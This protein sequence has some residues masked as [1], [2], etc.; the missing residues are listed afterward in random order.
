MV[1]YDY[2]QF[3]ALKLRDIIMSQLFTPITIKSV[4]MRN[5]VGVAPMCQYHAINGVA[6]NWHQTHIGALAMGGA[7]LIIMEATGVRSDGRITPYCLGLWNDEQVEALKPIVKFAKQQ[8]A[9]MG[10]QLAHAVRKGSSAR[11]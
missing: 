1:S 8:G 9:T 2:G 11:P 4:T 5:R 3:I 7:G 10:I 6:Q